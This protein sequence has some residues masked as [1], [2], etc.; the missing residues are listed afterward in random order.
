MQFKKLIF[1]LCFPMPGT[2]IVD[3]RA[4]MKAKNF[5]ND[6]K[7]QDLFLQAQ[8]IIVLHRRISPC[9]RTSRN[10]NAPT[11]EPSKS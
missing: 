2:Q 5:V 4:T 9:N 6:H 8:T 3:Y 1:T 7:Q 11:I 10:T